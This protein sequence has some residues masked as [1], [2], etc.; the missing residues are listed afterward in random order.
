V[1][2]S[3]SL[4]KKIPKIK[5]GFYAVSGRYLLLPVKRQGSL[6]LGWQDMDHQSA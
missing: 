3:G 6:K 1:D 5:I 4:E 2:A